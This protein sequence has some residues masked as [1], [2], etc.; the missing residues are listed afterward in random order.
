[1]SKQ[2]TINGITEDDLLDLRGLL[3]RYENL[4]KEPLKTR[5]PLTEE[6]SIRIAIGRIDMAILSHGLGS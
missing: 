5:T 2:L 3:T 4:L 1:M 6:E